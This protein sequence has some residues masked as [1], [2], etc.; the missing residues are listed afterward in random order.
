MLQEKKIDCPPPPIPPPSE[1]EGKG[2]ATKF[3]IKNIW[4]FPSPFPSPLRG[5]GG[6]EGGLISVRDKFSDINV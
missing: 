6:G 3:L 5:E 4:N 2:K 1:G